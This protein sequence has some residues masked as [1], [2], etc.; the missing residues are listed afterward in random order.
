MKSRSSCGR[1]SHAKSAAR[2]IV[3]SLCTATPSFE[4]RLHCSRRRWRC[5]PV[6][7]LGINVSRCPSGRASTRRGGRL[8]AVAALPRRERLN[9]NAQ[10]KNGNASDDACQFF[11]GAVV[12]VMEDPVQG[13]SHVANSPT[14][15][16]SGGCSR[17]QRRARSVA[18]PAMAMVADSANGSRHYLA[19]YAGPH[20]SDY[21]HR[22]RQTCACGHPGHG[23]GDR[24]NALRREVILHRILVLLITDSAGSADVGAG[25]RTLTAAALRW[26]RAVGRRAY[27]RNQ[28]KCTTARRNG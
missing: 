25:R 8:L 15:P 23:H 13:S 11:K 16:A 6:L 10:R 26:G 24:R 28:G 14:T 19:C 21:R 1:N 2:G 20:S 4:R 22:Y 17:R 3:D 12:S 18:H 27:C 7:A 9:I 5:I